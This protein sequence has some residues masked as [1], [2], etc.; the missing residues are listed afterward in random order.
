[1][2]NEK[3]NNDSILFYLDN[4]FYKYIADDNTHIVFYINFVTLRILLRLQ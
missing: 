4:D 2:L 3:K 1:M